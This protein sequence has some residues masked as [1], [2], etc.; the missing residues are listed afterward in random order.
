MAVVTH[1]I[2]S[3]QHTIEDILDDAKRAGQAVPL[4]R[5]FVQQGLQREP[6][7]GPLATF[8]SRGRETALEQYLLLRALATKEPFNVARD[9]RIWARAI[10]ADQDKGRSKV[11]KQW[12]WLADQ[13]LVR[14][15]RLGRMA[16]VVALREDG[17]GLEYT[18]PGAKPRDPYFNLP[19][20]YWREGWYETLELP[21]KAMLLIA[22]SIRA[23]DF[24]LPAAQVPTWYGISESTAQRG[25]QELKRAKAMS[26]RYE[27]KP[28]GRAPEGF[29]RDTLYTLQTP[30]GPTG[31]IA[32]RKGSA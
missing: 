23:D 8:V 25:L 17:S 29:T 32:R 24:L 13:S 30:F 31:R 7:R 27:E 21:A 12:R 26:S 20:A 15:E 3:R 1:L 11:S 5:D 4:R 28:S 6:T 18:H 19:F 14:I 9:A 22:L 16:D 2:A 10:G